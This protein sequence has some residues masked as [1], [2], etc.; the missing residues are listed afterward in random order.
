MTSGFLSFAPSSCSCQAPCQYAIVRLI[1]RIR[2]TNTR[3]GVNKLLVTATDEALPHSLRF[4]ESAFASSKPVDVNPPVKFQNDPTHPRASRFRRLDN[5]CAFI[6]HRPQPHRICFA[7]GKGSGERFGGAGAGAAARARGKGQ[8][9]GKRPP[10]R[11]RRRRPEAARRQPA[12]HR[13]VCVCPIRP[14]RRD[15]SSPTGPGVRTPT[16]GSAAGPIAAPR[17]MWRLSLSAPGPYVAGVALPAALCDRKENCLE[18][19]EQC[20]MTVVYCLMNYVLNIYKPK[21][22]MPFG[23]GVSREPQKVSS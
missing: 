8:D 10:R 6:G 23:Q 16:C 11:R 19:R 22:Q 9:G 5:H 20:R 2:K 15:G 17:P 14:T 1:R 18:K 7:L 4:L 21:G 12:N 13:P 3:T